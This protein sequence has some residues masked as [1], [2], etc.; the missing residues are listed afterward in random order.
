MTTGPDLVSGELFVEY[1]RD[2]VRLGPGGA[3]GVIRRR[4]FEQPDGGVWRL[5]RTGLVARELRNQAEQVLVR[6]TRRGGS[7]EL[8]SGSRSYEARVHSEA[9]RA[10][11]N[12]V[13]R[14]RRGVLTDPAG[15]PVAEVRFTVKYGDKRRTY[16]GAPY[17]SRPISGFEVAVT[18]HRPTPLPLLVTLYQITMGSAG[19]VSFMR[20]LHK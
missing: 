15:G 18:A 13:A 17:R 20:T 9:R 6:V 2:G 7:Y 4:S 11:T 5:T 1:R 3:L 8:E 14:S 12:L 19:P 16:D 10:V